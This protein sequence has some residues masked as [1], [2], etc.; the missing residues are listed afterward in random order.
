MCENEVS[1]QMMLD[2]VKTQLE[3]LATKEDMLGTPE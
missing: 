3:T 2:K 1:L